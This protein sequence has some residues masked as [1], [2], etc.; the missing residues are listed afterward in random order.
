MMWMIVRADDGVTLAHFS[1]KPKALAAALRFGQDGREYQV[2]AEPT[3]HTP[4][5]RPVGVL[6]PMRCR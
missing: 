6:V 4:P 2:I 5:Y 1:C 3:P